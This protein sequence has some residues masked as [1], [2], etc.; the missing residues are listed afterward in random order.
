V[1]L[2]IFERLELQEQFED[3]KRVIRSSKLKKDRQCNDQKKKT[4]GKTLIYKHYTEN[5][6]KNRG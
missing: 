6:C 4:K 5:K 3:T 2:H 1:N